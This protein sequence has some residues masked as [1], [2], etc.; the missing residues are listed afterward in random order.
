M[1]TV[2]KIHSKKKGEINKFLSKFSV[3]CIF[4]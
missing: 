4:L 3:Q 1:A 2:I